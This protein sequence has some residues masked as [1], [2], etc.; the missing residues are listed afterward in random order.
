M[1]DALASQPLAPTQRGQ[2]WRPTADGSRKSSTSCF[3]TGT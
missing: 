2:S 1:A 3:T